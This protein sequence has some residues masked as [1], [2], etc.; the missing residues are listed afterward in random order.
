MTYFPIRQN[1]R[2]HDTGVAQT[3]LIELYMLK[4]EG[5]GDVQIFIDVENI[6]TPKNSMHACTTVG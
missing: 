5:Q 2:R 1:A 3:A 4:Q 6:E